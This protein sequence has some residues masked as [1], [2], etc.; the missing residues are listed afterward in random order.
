MADFQ[1]LALLFI[2][3]KRSKLRF[4]TTQESNFNSSSSWPGDQPECPR[5]RRYGYSHFLLSIPLCWYRSRSIIEKSLRNPSSPRL[6]WLIFPAPQAHR[7]KLRPDREQSV[8]IDRPTG[9]TFC[10]GG[11]LRSL[12]M[13]HIHLN[14][15]IRKQYS[16]R[17]SDPVGM[18]GK[19]EY[20]LIK[21]V[22]A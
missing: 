7:R 2:C 8:G 6:Q 16:C 19:A 9:S 22:I 3:L 13:F 20:C 12:P 5:N 18:D 10:P 4:E 14:G 1:H 17:S 11:G 15:W 21:M